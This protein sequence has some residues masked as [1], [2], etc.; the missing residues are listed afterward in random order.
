MSYARPLI[1][2]VIV[3][4][5]AVPAQAQFF[6]SNPPP[7]MGQESYHIY[8]V[9]GVIASG[10]L[11]TFFACTNT[12]SASIRVG[13]EGFGAAGGPSIN[14]PSFS[15]L[16]ISSGGTRIFGTT[17]AVGISVSSNV[18]VGTSQGSARI[19]A[20]E[21][22]GIICSAF[23]ADNGNDPPTSMADLKVVAKTKQRGE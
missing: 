16:D 18:A 17:T 22:K 8:S 13:V 11:G 7:L 3:L 6:Y 23:V 5:I 15:S 10:S 9:P 21:K 2:A 20:T 19:L 12:T 1:A 4:A 14:D